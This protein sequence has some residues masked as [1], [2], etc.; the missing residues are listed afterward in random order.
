[1][2]D[3]LF[4]EGH[5]QLDRF[6]RQTPA[7]LIN[8]F[9]S[10][11][12]LPIQLRD[13]APYLTKVKDSIEIHRGILI[14]RDYSYYALVYLGRDPRETFEEWKR[15]HRFRNVLYLERTGFATYCI[16]KGERTPG[17]ILYQIRTK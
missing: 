6:A 14:F 5:S 9:A 3:H 8:L 11:L 13:K 4:S 10:A 7:V 12:E 16:L 1:M 2:A 17:H 15:L